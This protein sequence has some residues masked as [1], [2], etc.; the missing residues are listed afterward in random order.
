[1]TLEDVK[2]LVHS[3]AV[4]HFSATNHGISLNQALVSPRRISVTARDV[5]RGRTKEEHLDVWL[6]GRERD[7]DGYKIILRDDGMFGLASKGFPADQNPILVGWYG[8]LV[9]TFLGM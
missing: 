2:E 1:M 9:S 5:R 6:V 7:E 4:G 3:Q 8:G